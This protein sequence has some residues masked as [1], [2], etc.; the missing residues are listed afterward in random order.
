MD[1]YDVADT[2]ELIGT[3][4]ELKGENPFRV[5]A[6]FT[7]AQTIRNTTADLMFYI[8]SN[9]LTTLKGVGKDLAEKITDLAIHGD[10]KVLSELKSM[11]PPGVLELL[12][13]PG[14]GPKRVK[15]L[16][17]QLGI[18]SISELKY[19]CERHQLQKLQGFG[20]KI[21][22]NILQGIEQITKST[23]KFLYSIA[24]HTADI[25]VESISQLKGVILC[26][27]AGSVRRK[28]EVIGD[29]DILVS[30]EEYDIQKTSA[31][32]IQL[33]QIEQVTGCGET[34]ISTILKNGIQCDIRLV[35]PKS[36]PFALQYFT[37]SKEHNVALRTRAKAVGLS[38]NEYNFSSI[39]KVQVP[40]CTTEDDI[41]KSLGLHPIP[42]ELRENMG[43]IEEAET[44]IPKLISEQDIRGAFH[45]HTT[46]SDGSL[47]PEELCEAAKAKHWKFIGIADHTKSAAYANGM[48]IE[49][50]KRQIEHVRK[51]STTLTN[52]TIFLGVEC[53]ILPDGS[54]D[55]PDSL[56]Q[57]YDY[58]V[59]SIHSKFKMTET[60][61]TER[62]INAL[63]NR[64]STIL[65]HPTGR[66]LLER[67]GYPIN[68]KVVIDV[69]AK[70]QKVI[71]INSHPKR[72]DLDWR[73][74]RYAKQ[75]GVKL[76]IS[77]DAHNAEGLNDT[78]YGVGIARK[79]WL[80]PRDI[81]NTWSNTA[82]KT[83]FETIRKD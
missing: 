24:K 43:E 62:I 54:L 31:E 66:L 56:L 51:L 7:A 46:Y 59:V 75:H 60:E 72:L 48:S 70:L 3:L 73:W 57:E 33:T 68:L 44:G 29:I 50:A 32:I 36:Y 13:I 64:Y 15:I 71:E 12:K 21:E 37:G 11:F 34:K 18:A 81:L 53:D 22:E 26:E 74:I 19:A 2:L 79:G 6:Y 49:T 27:V 35:Q 61:A 82:I 80:E 1:K 39:S 47:T 28:K 23:G 65:G 17:E 76:C 58:V 38:L 14:L 5:R 69:A 42:P 77:P 4:L 20:T 16:Y 9:S 83:L 52:F 8:N 30:V 41:Y 25:L 40:R 63:Q 78:Y 55:F 10:T 67:E 45:C